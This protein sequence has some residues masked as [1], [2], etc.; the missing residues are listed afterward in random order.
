MLPRVPHHPVVARAAAAAATAWLLAGCT[1]G[2]VAPG[3][4]ADPPVPDDVLDL[5]VIGDS[6]AAG[7]GAQTAMTS[8]AWETGRDLGART[9]VDAVGGTGFVNPGPSG[10]DQRYATRV[11]ALPDAV[12]DVD[13][14][15]VEGGLNDRQKPPDDVRDAA[16]GVLRSLVARAPHAQVVLVGAT[17]PQ[18][19]AAQDSVAVNTALAGAA[20]A[21]GVVFVDPV[22]R[23][24][25][26]A[27][28][29]AE[30][31]GPDGLHPTQAGHDHLAR[32]LAEVVADLP[33]G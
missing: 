3:P 15:V 33:P 26:P 2:A 23:G 12:L 18:P 22:A 16:E 7:D 17:A 13:V 9:A 27:D 10:R 14:V 31:V 25:F 21:V 5:L 11:A 8:F 30:Y 29:V 20:R 28:E 32:L 1:A 6:Y 19:A 4:V 24:W